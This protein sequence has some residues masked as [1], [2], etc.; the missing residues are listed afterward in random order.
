VKGNSELGARSE[1]AR[2]ASVGRPAWPLRL[3]AFLFGLIW[4]LIVVVPV[5]YM[6]L[7]SFRSD[8][9]YLSDNP[10]LPIGG[11][12]LSSYRTV[13]SGTGL[14][15]DFR[16]SIVLAAAT[17]AVV[18]LAS[19]AAAFRIVTRGSRFAA[20]SFRLLLFGLA[21]PIQA[22]VIP[23]FVLVT[24]LHIYDTLPTLVVVISA[25]LIAVAV[26]LNV[27]YVR[28]IPKELF[29]A[30]A[31]DGANQHTV[32]FQLVLPMSR[33]IMAVVAIFAGL[34][35]WN[36]FLLPLILTQSQNDSVLTLGLVKLSTVAQY[37]V[38]VPIVMAGVLLSVLPLVILYVGLHRQFVKGLGGLALR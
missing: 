21:V 1:R 33:P 11:V 9:Q 20:V 23:I 31:V 7:T 14:A 6:V 35:A 26:L 17:V 13:F 25:S 32:F 18:V 27:N 22:I 2:L 34:G 38:D 28:A 8:S 10:W 29:D 30:M 37:G 12:S 16:N 19:L 5:Y 4:L 3:G 36:N 15:T 24:K